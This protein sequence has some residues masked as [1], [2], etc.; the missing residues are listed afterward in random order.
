MS[1]VNHQG[2]GSAL[3]HHLQAVLIL[4]AFVM[5]ALIYGLVTPPFEAGDESR[6]FAVVKYMSDT[7]RLIDQTSPD[8][9]AIRHHWSHE[10]NQ[11]PLFYALAAALTFWIDTDSWD[12]V[13]WY[14][15]HTT[16]GDPL[17]PDNKNIT[18][19]PAAED[20]PWTNHVLAV[21]LI[22][23]LS[24]AMA[25]V[26]VVGCYALA[27]HLFCGNRW[28]ASGAMAITAFNPMF[29]FISASINNDNAVIMFVTLALWL[30]VHMALRRRQ[31][32]GTRRLYGYA[33]LLG[34]LIGLGALSKLYAL[35]LLPLAG[36]LFIWLAY[37]DGRGRVD[38][39]TA[40]APPS[41]SP[42]LTLRFW[43]KVSLSGAILAA[44][45]AGLAGWFYARNALLYDGD[46]LALQIMRDT[47]GQ[48][49][50]VPSLTTIS[51]EFEGFRIAYWALF[52]GVNILADWW[53]YPVLDWVS[54]MA[55]IG[56]IAFI[57]A[58][59]YRA[60]AN[61]RGRRADLDQSYLTGRIARISQPTF[62]IL[63]SWYLI[64]ITGF[65]IWNVTQPAGQ[66]R[67]LYPAIAAISA[68]GMLGL[69]WWLPRI[70]QQAVATVCTV[71]LFFFAAVAPVRYIAPAYTKPPILT[72]ADLPAE[73]QPVNLVY[74]EAIRLVGYQTH[75]E[76][77]R[78][79]ETLPLTLYWQILRPV[80]LDYSI[81]V[82]L[83]GRQRQVIGQV[84]TYPGGGLWPSTLLASGSIVADSYEVPIPAETEFGQAPARLQ[85]AAG[86]YD[87]AEP[88]RPG[89]PAKNADGQPVDP[90]IGTA[91]LVPW[92]W[93]EP[94]RFDTSVNFF[95]K[96]TLI[97][98]QMADDQQSVTLN[99]QANDRFETDYTV[100]LQAWHTTEDEYVTGFD[101]PPVQ[102]D[103]PTS[104]W[105]PGE[106]IID[107]HTL[108]LDDLAPGTYH[109]L[110]GLYDPVTGER[111][112]AFG[113]EGPLPDYAVKLG[114]LEVE[115]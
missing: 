46:L 74:D 45:V 54:L 24:I 15:P 22:R 36:G 27:L 38:R 6:H 9:R 43:Q 62:I 59:S 83:L 4:I 64:M 67:L 17:R 48:R 78:P 111:L 8:I 89:R 81:F 23:L 98:F 33:A 14:N 109:L 106:I 42:F 41:G 51:T 35:G 49:E 80:D 39:D 26:T 75:T 79:A 47:A 31:F 72:E 104:F 90:I 71:A 28:L 40:S 65:V 103:Y 101:G 92:H 85:I 60:L 73:M 19:H 7:G 99:W 100:F 20:W 56:V 76:L 91:K 86:V 82:H 105:R 12:Q 97:S 34:L 53:I 102:G 115:K 68:L 58:A 11:P 110:G 44:V 66:G 5:L 63:L 3:H 96:A 70:G 21:R 30:M 93:P 88:G 52:G 32:A 107:E 114:T 94:A 61:R 18:I 2:P 95:E 57:V 112:P 108:D 84:D 25:S 87:Y 69:T 113:P 13:F 29:I 10:G 77:V 1:P 16:I 55:V 37:E 50:T